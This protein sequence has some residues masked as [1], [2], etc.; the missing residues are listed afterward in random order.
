MELSPI[1][2]LLVKTH[3]SREAAID[4]LKRRMRERTSLA[5]KGKNPDGQFFMIRGY[6][7]A[8]IELEAAG[9]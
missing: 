5:V 4:H 2:K 3:G 8:L 1:T 6:L 7:K 9:R